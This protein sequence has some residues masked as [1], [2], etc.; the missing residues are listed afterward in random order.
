LQDYL[1][2]APG[3]VSDIYHQMTDKPAEDPKR[4]MTRDE[5]FESKRTP[6]VSL[7][8]AQQRA[9]ES[10]RNS[11]AYLQAV[12][13][14]QRTTAQRMI[15]K[16][17]ENAETAWKKT[18]TNQASDEGIIQSQWEAEVKDRADRENAVLRQPWY[19]RH[20]VAGDLAGLGALPASAWLARRGFNKIAD[21]T[22]GLVK[23]AQLARETGNIGK[24]AEALA[25]LQSQSNRL[26]WEYTK[27]LAK[28][29]LLPG[30]LRTT[31][32][33]W[34]AL[35]APDILN[36]ET[37]EPDP[38]SA[39]QQARSLMTKMFATSPGATLEEMGPSFM[40]GL[41]GTAI[42]GALSR[43]PKMAE[44]AA[45]KDYIPPSALR[46]TWGG[47]GPNV[48]NKS[49]DQFGVAVGKDRVKLLKQQNLVEDMIAARSPKAPQPGTGPQPQAL[50]ENQTGL[51]GL[52]APAKKPR[53]AGLA[54]AAKPATRA[55][56]RSPGPSAQA[57]TEALSN[58]GIS[59]SPTPPL[60]MESVKDDL[61]IR[62]EPFSHG[63]NVHE[64]PLLSHVAG[65]TDHL[66]I[67]VKA[68]SYIV[69]ADIVSA[70]GQGNTLAGTKI[71]EHMFPRQPEKL[72][73]ATGGTVPI[74]AAG[75]EVAL[76]PEQV[77]QVGSG[78]L[79][80]GH[81]ILDQFVKDTRKN[82]IKTLQS[83]PGPA[84]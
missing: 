50:L 67:T 43:Y 19:Q 81:R 76:T 31:G 49:P 37:H 2:K 82:T 29:V 72:A 71:V 41:E 53:R 24:E 70:L 42:G 74:M 84:H 69:P 1:K 80:M 6:K 36:P 59:A 34:D 10:S 22:N 12:K 23:A 35:T 21:T 30:G 40:T 56:S 14:G 61:G 39:R 75:G 58:Q 79:D 25:A 66:P 38:T 3:L 46:P 26:P 13:D 65:R 11:E 7:M 17:R 32:T 77:E 20:P 64:G 18:Q 54:G 62:Q 28:P 16:A 48:I 44:M 15:D 4:T 68:G 51:G 78:D 55:R 73:Y 5:F 60:S 63:G 47:Y 8:D 57:E 33:A 27:A 83:L 9:E 52:P 45:Q